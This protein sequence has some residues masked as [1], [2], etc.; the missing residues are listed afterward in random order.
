MMKQLL[1]VLV[2]CL[3]FLAVHAETTTTDIPLEDELTL[4]D[5]SLATTKT[6]VIN[7]KP[8]KQKKY[9]GSA[10]VG[11][12]AYP[13]V[14]NVN[15]GYNVSV[16]AGYYINDQIMLDLGFALAKSQMSIGNLLLPNQRDD[17]EI[18]QYQGV[19][20]AKYQLDNIFGTN[21]K[22]IAGAVVSY[23]YRKYN[24]RNGLTTNSGNTGNSTAIDAGIDVG[25]DYDL[26]QTYALGLDL[27]YMFNLANHVSSNY[28]NPSYGYKG[29]PLESLQYYIAGLSARMN[30]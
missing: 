16:A 4:S 7:D 17:F 14:S 2:L 5:N 13:E 6:Q 20:G 9:Y 3:S 8:Q 27:K 10:I 11:L 12:A 18:S 28:V 23:T 30:F 24:L 15:K 19:L 26:S 29:T 1:A 22:P 25:I 21:F